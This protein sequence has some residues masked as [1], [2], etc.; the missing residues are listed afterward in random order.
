MRSGPFPRAG[1]QSQRR[2]ASLPRGLA[3]TSTEPVVAWEEE[4]KKK[5]QMQDANSPTLGVVEG[6][7]AW[8]GG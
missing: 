1:H 2:G 6:G 7:S 4:G 8:E 5:K 3:A